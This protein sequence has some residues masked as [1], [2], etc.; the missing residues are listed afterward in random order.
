AVPARANITWSID[1]MHFKMANGAPARTLNVIDDFSRECL[2]I[3]GGFGTSAALVAQQ[4]ADLI[5]KRGAP[6]TIRC[7]NGPEFTG[8]AF[9]NWAE[10]A[11]ITVEHIAPYRPDQN[12][13]VESFNRIVR[14]QMF[15]W[16]RFKSLKH[17][18]KVAEEFRYQYNHVRPHKSLGWAT[19]AAYAAAHSRI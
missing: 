8:F 18:D 12:G 6:K 15:R 2:M 11:G 5:A 19:P 14:S 17:F 4:L 9:L 10:Q 1:F 7:D 13:Y 3:K 16:N